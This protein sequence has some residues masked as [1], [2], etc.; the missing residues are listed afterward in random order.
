MSRMWLLANCFVILVKKKIKKKV[1]CKTSILNYTSKWLIALGWTDAEIPLN[2][3]REAE[4]GW[5][6]PIMYSWSCRNIIRNIYWLLNWGFF[7]PDPYPRKNLWQNQQL[8]CFVDVNS[9][10]NFFFIWKMNLQN[11]C[12]YEQNEVVLSWA[13]VQ[14]ASDCTAVRGAAFCRLNPSN[15]PDSSARSKEL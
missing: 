3:A 7:C 5:T 1:P 14:A 11:V 4:A 10:M 13:A 8:N 12:Y 2:G 6:A 15:A 9:M